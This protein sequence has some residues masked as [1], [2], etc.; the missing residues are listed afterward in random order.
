VETRREAP[1]STR[2]IP[3]WSLVG[4][5]LLVAGLPGSATAYPWMIRHEYTGCGVCHVDPSGAGLLTDYGRAQSALLLEMQYG[6]PPKGDEAPKSADFLFGVLPLPD[7]LLAQI[8]YRGAG[9]WVRSSTPG[10]PGSPSTTVTDTRYLQM[11][12]DGRAALKIGPFRASGSLGWSNSATTLPAA[13]VSN[14]DGSTQLVGREYWLGLQLAEDTVLVRVGRMNVPF[15]LRNVEHVAWVRDQTD[16]SIN[17][18]QQSGVAVAYDNAKVRAEVM[19]LLGNLNVK[20]DSFRQRGASGLV[21]VV[22][23]ERATLG[24]S[25]LVAR[26]GQDSASGGAPVLRQV[27]GVFSRWAVAEP[28]VLTAE[29]DVYLHDVLG[30]GRTQSNGAAWLQ[31]DYEPIQGLHL[32]PAVEALQTYGVNGVG[33]GTWLTV[34]W[35]CLPHTELRLDAVWR[36]TPATYGSTNTFSLLLQLHVYL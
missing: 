25:A 27:Y 16:T 30:S 18:S 33:V 22:M 7:W 36:N 19:A 1:S 2:A 35:F 6:N 31:V 9:F 28:V 26:A 34:D 5:G 4:I 8:S 20:P 24:L 12:L 10:P 32:Q 23:A 13:V 29:A 11:L 3:P 15:G 14:A 17:V 21:E